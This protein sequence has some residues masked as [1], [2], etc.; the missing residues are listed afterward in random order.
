MRQL[1]AVVRAPVTPQ[2]RLKGKKERESSMLSKRLSGPRFAP[3]PLGAD[4]RPGY[5]MGNQPNT[6]TFRWYK[7]HLKTAIMRN[8]WESSREQETHSVQKPR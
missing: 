2:Q 7:V 4:S 6:K 3:L 5:Q 8:G 1:H